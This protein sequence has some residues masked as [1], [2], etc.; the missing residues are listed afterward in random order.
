MNFM[1]FMRLVKL[2]T[3]FANRVDL[4]YDLGGTR[5]GTDPE[6][7]DPDGLDP[8]EQ[9][10]SQRSPRRARGTGRSRPGIREHDS[11]DVNAR[12]VFN[13]SGVVARRIRGA[14]AVL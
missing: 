12:G 11:I 10:A 3:R 7:A 2:K 4:D 8:A 5:L 1:S 6:G 9:T 14:A 13:A